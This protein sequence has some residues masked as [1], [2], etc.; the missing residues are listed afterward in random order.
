MYCF[1]VKLTR[2]ELGGVED[3]SRSTVFPC[4]S[5]KATEMVQFLGI[6][7]QRVAP[8]RCLDGHAKEPYEMSIEWEPYRR[9]NFFSPLADLYAVTCITEISLII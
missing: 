6:T 5:L 9:Y 3:A 2:G 1:L 7:V 8:C 4:A